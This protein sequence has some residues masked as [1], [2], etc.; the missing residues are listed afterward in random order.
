MSRASDIAI[1]PQILV[2]AIGTIEID[3]LQNILD[4]NDPSI[5]TC[6]AIAMLGYVGDGEENTRLKMEL[7]LRRVGPIKVT[8]AAMAKA[9]EQNPTCEMVKTLLD[10]GWP[11]TQNILQRTTEWGMA[12]IFKLLL[13]AGGQLTPK[14]IAGS[15]KKIH[16]G[17]VMVTLVVSLMDRPLNDNLWAQMMLQY[18]EN[19]WG[20]PETLQALL[21]MKPGLKVPK[22]F[23]IA[24]TK[25]SMKG[26]HHSGYHF[27]RTADR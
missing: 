11:V 4:R 17:N 19:T 20:S 6:D 3:T 22:W 7:Q 8:E 1:T 10:H 2:N 18:V 23:L 24:F 15:A 14:M 13:E 27:K 5:I 25:N 16:D 26:E 9:L 21:E 12:T